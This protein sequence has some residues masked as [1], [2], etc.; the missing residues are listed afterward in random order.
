M[1]TSLPVPGTRH[2]IAVTVGNVVIGG[3]APVV[4]Q[5]M[6]NT[7]TA[8][9]EATFRQVKDLVQRQYKTSLCRHVLN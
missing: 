3:A 6:T 7:D 8:D 2:S 1:S 9:V 5:S 4:V